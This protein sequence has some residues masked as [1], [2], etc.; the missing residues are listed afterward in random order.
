MDQCAMDGTRRTLR[1][2][3]RVSDRWAMGVGTKYAAWIRLSAVLERIGS[4]R[5]PS[6]RKRRIGAGVVRFIVR[7]LPSPT[8]TCSGWGVSEFRE[9]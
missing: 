6:F 8:P 7:R 1:G 9:I 3:S 5:G 4:Q 2:S